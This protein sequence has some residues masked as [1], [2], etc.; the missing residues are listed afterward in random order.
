[1]LQS[2]A[3]SITLFGMFLQPCIMH[4]T[5]IAGCSTCTQDFGYKFFALALH[6]LD[7]SEPII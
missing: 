7:G 2:H 3:L 5:E 4:E 1:M 6:Y